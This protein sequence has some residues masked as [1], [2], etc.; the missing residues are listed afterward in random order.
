MVRVLHILAGGEH[1]GAETAYVDMCIAQHRAEGFEVAAACRPNAVRVP[2]LQA[3]GVPVTLLPFGGMFDFKTTPALKK[4]IAAYKPDI[5]QS[6]M[7]R[8]ASKTPR[9]PGVIHVSRLGG[10][11][12]IAKYYKNTDYFVGVA[13]DIADWIVKS[14]IPASRVTQ[15]NNFAETEAAA[16][17]ADRA[18][19]GTPQDAFLFVALGRLHINKAYDVLLKA[20]VMAPQAHVWI[21]GEGPERAALEKMAAELGVASRVRFLGW[22]SDRAALMAAADAVVFPSRHEPFGTTFVQA[23]EAKKPLVSTA[24]QGPAQYIRNGE[25]ALMTPVDD[26]GALAAAMVRVMQDG[27][28][29]DRLVTAGYV[30]YEAE[31]EKAHV[32]AHWQRYYGDLLLRKTVSKV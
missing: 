2:Q 11:Y 19:Q 14:G 23:W 3:A 30:R 12:D 6:W 10:Y 5:T 32:L 29:R 25:D 1:G 13:P 22:R 28:L 26:A 20:L 24:S 21:A 27:D 4:L 7:S 31:F 8:A 17:P 16:T 9:M 18:A 15:I